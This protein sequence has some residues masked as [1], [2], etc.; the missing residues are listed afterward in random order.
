MIIIR[1][2]RMLL[3]PAVFICVFVI[4]KFSG[5]Q[6]VVEREDKFENGYIGVHG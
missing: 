4:T 1:A 6:P 5:P 2:A 3:F